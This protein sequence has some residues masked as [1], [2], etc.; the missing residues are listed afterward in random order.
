MIEVPAS[1]ILAAGESRRMGS[2]KAMLR[3]QG[4]TFAGKLVSTFS[5]VCRPVILVTGA[6]PGLIVTPAI[7]VY[8]P[9]WGYG[10]LSSLQAGFR[11]LPDDCPACF[12]I[13]VD[14]PTVSADTVAQLWD[15]FT[16]R[17]SAGDPPLFVIPRFEGKRGHPVLAAR[18]AI[19]EIL[20]L[21]PNDQARDVVHRHQTRTEY[22]DV[23][24]PGILVDIDTPDDYRQ[25]V[26][27]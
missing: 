15:R 26:P 1:V 23:N 14:S 6:V 12:F 25:V 27:E 5:Q 20:A 13:P 11:A 3:I 21:S 4:T 7:S 24:D 18:P 16:A 9:D 2:A 10:Q 22:V 19:G 17:A 8:N